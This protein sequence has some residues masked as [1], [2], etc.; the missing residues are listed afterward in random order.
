MRPLERIQ[1]RFP[2]SPLRPEPLRPA[3]W[4]R[5]VAQRD[6]ESQSSR[7]QTPSERTTTR[8]NSPTRVSVNNSKRKSLAPEQPRFSPP[9]ASPDSDDFRPLRRPT[10]SPPPIL[11]TSSSSASDFLAEALFNDEQLHLS[12]QL[13][14]FAMHDGEEEDRAQRDL[15]VPAFANLLFRDRIFSPGMPRKRSLSVSEKSELSELSSLS[16]LS[17]PSSSHAGPSIL[18]TTVDPT[19]LSVSTT[20]TS[21]RRRNHTA[22]T[23]PRKRRRT[24]PLPERQKA[25]GR[26][27][28]GKKAASVAPSFQPDIKCDWPQRLVDD[29]VDKAF[30]QCDVCDS[31]YHYGC[32]GVKQGDQCLLPGEAFLCPPCVACRCVP[33]ISL[34][35]TST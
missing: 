19:S 5:Q 3:D 12:P 10:H 31:W 28:Q 16:S 4:L 2:S 29:P 6:A 8:T 27:S 21:K 23:N 15:P 7:S 26:K 25:K 14:Q 33:S 18:A 34:Y 11:S 9:P 13:S 22:T 35:S 32:V 24:E 17:T 20:K 1:S 30:I